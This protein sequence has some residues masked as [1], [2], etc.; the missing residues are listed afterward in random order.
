M[1]TDS[2]TEK[3]EEEIPSVGI[4]TWRF[5]WGV[6]RFRWR[7]Y[8][9]NNLVYNIM[10]LGWLVPGLVTREFFNLI[11]PDAS[12]RFDMVTLMAILFASGLVRV[13]G[14]LGLV[15]TN[16]PFEYNNHAL[17]H[18][19]M[20]SHIFRQPGARALPESP[21]AATARF[22]GDVNEL[23]LFALWMNDL[24]GALLHTIVAV[25]IMVSISPWI[26]LW[27]FAPMLPILW[28]ANAATS[29]VERYRRATR[30][31][32]AR[33]AGFIAETFGSIQAIKVANAEDRIIARFDTLN[34]RRRQTALQDRLFNELLGSIFRNAGSL[35]TGLILLLAAQSLQ[36]GSFTVGD[37][38]LFVAYLG[39]ITEF[40][41]MIGFMWAR[42]KQ[43]GVAV[44]RMVRLLPSAPP[45]ALVEPAPV[46]MDGPLPDVHYPRK[47]PADRLEQLEVRGLTC[48]HP[49]STRGIEDISFVLPRGSFT[50]ITG[51]VGSGKTTL[52]RALLGLLP[53]DRGEILWNGQPVDDPAS[54]L[55]PPRCAYT[56][57]IPRLFSTS[58]R[59]NLLLGLASKDEELQKALH[60]AVLEKDVAEFEDALD[61]MVGPKGVKLSG[62][63]IQR[64][65]AARMF[66]R[67]P[68]LLVFDD[69]SSALDVE[70]E[71]TMWERLFASS[72]NGGA[73]H[74][75]T[76]N[77][78]QD[79]PTCLVVSHR[80]A[81]LRRADQ[82]IVLKDGRIEDQGKLDDLLARSPEMVRLWEGDFATQGATV[83]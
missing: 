65:A 18:R 19:N 82:I 30:E 71:R 38:A 57:Q 5:I 4:P 50:V 33:V 29:R 3:S 9:L 69:L 11:A 1:K 52:V 41:G 13:G 61:T 39:F 76:Q 31:A 26:T 77:G 12:P 51:R 54:F 2:R 62:G 47:E 81:A 22:N 48:L 46:Y 68:E 67:T 44:G 8:L 63:Q 35:G 25:L 55:T 59:E 27:A 42:Y 28:V 37:L 66:A 7:L 70:T 74:D 10:I 17:L 21:G 32:G 6:I 34:E 24:C 15:R 58:L 83:S 23:P 36:R 16:T 75:G 78:Y 43:A 40:V 20:L 80:R 73:E 45:L 60:A 64:A 79:R 56:A 72:Q 53:R 49:D 14:V